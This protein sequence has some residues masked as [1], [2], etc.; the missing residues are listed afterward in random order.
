MKLEYF[1]NILN[2]YDEELK[3][4]LL[5]DIQEILNEYH[6]SKTI[7]TTFDELETLNLQADFLIFVKK[8]KANDFDK[9]IELDEVIDK[10]ENYINLDFECN[11]NKIEI[12]LF[13]LK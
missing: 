1:E 12:F 11:E 13:N 6:L 7:N 9:T 10:H 3:L 4:T 8:Y 5:N 2:H